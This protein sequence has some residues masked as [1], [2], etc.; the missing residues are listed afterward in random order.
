MRRTDF[1]ALNA[2]RLLGN[3]SMYSNPRNTAV[4]SLRQPDANIT[5][6]RRIRFFAYSLHALQSV[7]HSSSHIS[8]TSLVSAFQPLDESLEASAN[9]TS[10][11]D[12]LHMLTRLGFNVAEPWEVISKGTAESIF[13]ACM[14]LERCRDGIDYDIDGAVVKVNE[15][16][17]QGILGSGARAP[18]WALAFKF[19]S[20]EA[21]TKLLGIEVQVG[22]TGVLTPV[23]ILRPIVVG[24]ILKQRSPYQNSLLPVYRRWCEGGEGDAS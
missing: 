16:K 23:A 20:Q 7:N 14:R 3:S 10:Q 13:E 1:L 21:V 17:N 5:A 2:N 24:T 18:K 22:R 12:V 11:A 19:T 9:I 8:S 6:Q 15:L 4:G